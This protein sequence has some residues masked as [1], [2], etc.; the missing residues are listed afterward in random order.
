MKAH[1]YKKCG[2][3][4]ILQLE[5]AEKLY[6]NKNEV[7]VRAFEEHAQGVKVL[8]ATYSNVHRGIGHYSFITQNYLN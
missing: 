1:L 8:L 3:S 2:P 5:E 4:E 6:P 7:L